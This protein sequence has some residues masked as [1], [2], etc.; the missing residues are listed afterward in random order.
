MDPLGGG[1]PPD[2]GLA[3]QA[4]NQDLLQQN[5]LL[6]GTPCPDRGQAEGAGG[7]PRVRNNVCAMWQCSTT[8]LHPQNSHDCP[9]GPPDGGG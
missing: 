8:H 7:R 4:H 5:N 6:G 1:V 2:L 9:L 3:V